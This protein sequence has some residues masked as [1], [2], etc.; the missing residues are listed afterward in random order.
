MYGVD[1][2]I[3]VSSFTYTTRKPNQPSPNPKPHRQV[4]DQLF[5][6]RGNKVE[7]LHRML[8]RFDDP[9]KAPE[10]LSLKLTLVLSHR[11]ATLR[12]FAL[13][14]RSGWKA[15]KGLYDEYKNNYLSQKEQREGGRRRSSRTA[16]RA[17]SAAVAAGRGG[18][19][20]VSF[21]GGGEEARVRASVCV[22]EWVGLLGG[23]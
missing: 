9:A 6:P 18:G 15:E 20:L 1:C 10:A 3:G 21:L 17:S 5:G 19:V 14:D 11:D 8:Q 4:L 13:Q 22:Y 7:A 23:G 12:Q 16:T 2:G